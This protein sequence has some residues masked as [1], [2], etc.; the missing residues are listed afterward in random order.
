MSPLKTRTIKL[1]EDEYENFKAIADKFHIIFQVRQVK[2]VY[3]IKAPE[4]VIIEWGY[5]E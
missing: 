3:H 5:D 2:D 1:T 4:D